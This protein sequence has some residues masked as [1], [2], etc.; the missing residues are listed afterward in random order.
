MPSDVVTLQAEKLR[1]RAEKTYRESMR[2]IR[3]EF[4]RKHPHYTPPEA[5][6]DQ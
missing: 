4:Q 2:Q 6:R 3:E 1:E 5:S